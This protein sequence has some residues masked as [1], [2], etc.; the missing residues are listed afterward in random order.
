VIAESHI[1][2]HTTILSFGIWGFHMGTKQTL[3]DL[4]KLQWPLKTV[5]LTPERLGAD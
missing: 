2:V 3:P 1:A 5:F 4:A